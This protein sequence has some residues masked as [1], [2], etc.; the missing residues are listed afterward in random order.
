MTTTSMTAVELPQGTVLYDDRGS[1]EILVF[2]HGL[3]MAGSV[4]D[5]VVRR[6]EPSFR[7][8]VPELPFGAHTIPLRRDADVSPPGVARLVA[9]MLEAIDVDSVT[10][11]GNDTGGAIAQ[12]VAAYDPERIGRLVLTNCDAYRNFLPRIFSY[13]Q[14][15]ARIPITSDLAIPS[16]RIKPLRRTPMAFGWLWKR[17]DDDLLDC[18]L[19]PA[20]RVAAIRRDARKLLAGINSSTTVEAAKQLRSFD[21]PALIAWAPE[22]R[23]SSSGSPSDSS[24]T[25]HWRGSGGSRTRLRSLPSTSPSGRPA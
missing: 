20:L 3:L 15:V 16:M 7:C 4:W 21:K 5:E 11:I 23:V 17:L 12:L 13:L 6:L 19:G 2:L 8:I 18:W 24:T 1:G 22:D 14:L 10:L 9:D 25:Y